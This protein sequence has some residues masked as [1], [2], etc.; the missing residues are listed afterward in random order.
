MNAEE[1]AYI[2]K[3]KLPEWEGYGWGVQKIVQQ[4]IDELRKLDPSLVYV[5]KKEQT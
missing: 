2:E 4:L 1:L 3:V 5:E